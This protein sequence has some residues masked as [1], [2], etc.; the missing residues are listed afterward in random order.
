MAAIEITKR[1]YAPSGLVGKFYVAPFASGGSLLEP[2]GNVLEASTEQTEE[3]EKQAD[4][5]VLGG[6]THAEIRRVTGVKFKAKIA[7]L[8]IVNMARSLLGTVSPED[9]GT[10][11]DVPGVVRRGA[12]IP[13][14][15]IN[16]TN[17]VLKKGTDVIAS[18]GNYDLLPE[19]IWVR[20]DAAGLADADAITYSYSY[21]DQVVIEA[22]TAKAPELQIRFAGLNEAD[23]GRP[24]VMDMWRVSQ[25]VTKQLSIV[26][27]GFGALDVEG[28]LLQ[29]PSKVGIG[30]SRYM[31]TIHV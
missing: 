21:A 16:V 24:V 30:I 31:R 20:A 15:H 22:L 18:A 23:S 12:L 7:D 27:K 3:V 25:G 1:T 8:N 10:V 11:A 29:D 2:I 4:M 26:K 13:L 28:E 19:G 5:T 14:P 17:L 9:A 6:G